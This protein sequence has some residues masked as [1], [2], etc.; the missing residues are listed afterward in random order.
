M[1]TSAFVVE[2]F[3][4]LEGEG[5]YTGHPTVF[6]RLGGCNLTCKGFNNPNLEEVLDFNPKDYSNLSDLPAITKGC[7]SNYAVSNKFSHL[8]TKMTPKELLNNLTNNLLPNKNWSTRSKNNY[9]L[10][11]TGGEPTLHQDFIAEFLIE[12]YDNV[13]YVPEIILIETNGTLNLRES[14]INDLN[15]IVESENILF[16]WSNSLKLSNSG[17]DINKTINPK[18]L[19]QQLQVENSKQYF[20]FVVDGSNAAIEEIEDIIDKY[21]LSDIINPWNI[22]LMPA[23]C[24]NTQLLETGRLVADQCIEFGYKFSTRLQNTLWNN[25][26][27]T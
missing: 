23:A 14:F 24:T 20:K 3:I 11:I 2:T 19:R 25:E 6:V 10:S 21:N 22:Y 27:G 4:S 17:E 16:V 13:Y 26:V 1:S 15:S 9:I 12:L 5:F 7:D 8:W 18:V